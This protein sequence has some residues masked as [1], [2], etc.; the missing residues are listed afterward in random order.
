M[1]GD[2]AETVTSASILPDGTMGRSP[3]LMVPL[4]G[5]KN[6]TISG[7]GLVTGVGD[8]TGQPISRSSMQG[9]GFARH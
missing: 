5:V 6:N 7:D 8:F 4:M 1:V 2:R 9:A 3:R